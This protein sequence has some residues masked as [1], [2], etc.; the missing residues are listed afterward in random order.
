[1]RSLFLHGNNLDELLILGSFILFMMLLG[2]VQFKLSLERKARKRRRAARKKA[3][4]AAK[5]N[6]DP[7]T[8]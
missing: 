4:E 7:P 8:I 2:M 3:S 1:M 5:S 6:T